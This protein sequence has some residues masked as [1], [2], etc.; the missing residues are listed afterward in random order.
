M[1]HAILKKQYERKKIVIE[2]AIPTITHDSNEVV[3]NK[4]EI[5][6]KGSTRVS[7]WIFGQ[8]FP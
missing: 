8:E 7:E 6:S 5:I 4:I 2:C 1:D 3:Y